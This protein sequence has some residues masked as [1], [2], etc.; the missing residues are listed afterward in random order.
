MHK[1]GVHTASYLRSAGFR[2]TGVG[3]TA[4]C[5]ECKL[6]IC[7]WTKDMNPFQIHA[8]EA[9]TCPLVLSLE[10]PLRLSPIAFRDQ[11]ASTVQ[12]NHAS[13]SKAIQ[14]NDFAPSTSQLIEDE[15]VKK[16]RTQT[17]SHWPHSGTLSSG[18][19]IDAGLSCCNKD[20]R[21][22]CIYCDKVFHK[23][24]P[25]VDDPINV[26][27]TLSPKCPFV[28]SKLAYHGPINIINDKKKSPTNSIQLLDMSR[29]VKPTQQSHNQTQSEGIDDSIQGDYFY[30]NKK[31]G[32]SCPD[33][34]DRLNFTGS[35]DTPLIEH[36][37]RNPH[38]SFIRRFLTIESIRQFLS[39]C[40]KPRT[41]TINSSTL[42]QRVQAA[43]ALPMSQQLL[44]T[45]PANIIR[46]CWEVQLRLNG[47]Q[48]QSKK[49]LFFACFI[50]QKQDRHING[51]E[52]NIIVPSTRMR[53]CEQNAINA[54]RQ[55]N[56]V[57]N[58]DLCVICMQFKR[59][60][61]CLPCGHL[62]TC[63][64]CGYSVQLCPVC[65]TPIK[66]FFRINL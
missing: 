56:D 39:S 15:S 37:R 29:R 44:L 57:V 19:M 17:F 12:N 35:N 52:D 63:V 47:E 40:N 9:P 11:L 13:E 10:Y 59:C 61:S 42:S 58:I 6:S 49:D 8:K 4:R 46:Q 64:Q 43:M 24:T 3:D 34:G 41:P 18:N 33:C 25:H 51:N 23:W 16:A 60:L 30:I 55:R 66:A 38:C 20:D 2:Y 50:R 27:K 32:V 45:I 26:H 62:A 65:R 14:A 54:Y 1:P 5:D 48:F 31:N 53:E 7:N 28:R 22:L 36:A 21:A